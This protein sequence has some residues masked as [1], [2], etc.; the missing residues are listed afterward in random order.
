[1]YHTCEEIIHEESIGRLNLYSWGV[2]LEEPDKIKTYGNKPS[3]KKK[4]RRR[5]DLLWKGV[6]EDVFED[7]LHFFYPKEARNF[8]LEKG[9]TF[10]DKELGQLFPPDNDEYAPRHVDKLARVF[11]RS[12]EEENLL[13]HLEVQGYRDKG[14]PERMFQYYYRV[15][16][17][18][19][20]PLTALAILTDG[21][22]RFHPKAFVQQRLDTCLSYSFKTYKLLEQDTA[23]LEQSDNPFAIVLLA[24]RAAL[25]GEKGKR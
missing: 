12:G 8:D 14:F 16:D 5:E 3:G 1:M 2:C 7:F 22:K 23:V 19:R 15:W 17:K 21:N 24:A 10:L 6:I 18:F 13:I 20:R 9:V 4:R 25:T 11:T